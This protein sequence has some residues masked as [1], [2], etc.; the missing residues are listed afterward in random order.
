MLMVTT[1]VGALQI[2]S[3]DVCAD[4]CGGAGSAMAGVA[5]GPQGGTG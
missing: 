5:A 4:D 3:S 1:R 2:G